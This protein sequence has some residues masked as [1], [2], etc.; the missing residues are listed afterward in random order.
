MP[1][2]SFHGTGQKHIEKKEVQHGFIFIRERIFLI[3][4]TC[5]ADLF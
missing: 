2:L 1:F 4:I 5:V 3:V